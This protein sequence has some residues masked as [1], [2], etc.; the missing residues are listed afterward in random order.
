MAWPRPLGAATG[1]GVGQAQISK[2]GSPAARHALVEAAWSAAKAPGPLRAFAERTAARR[3]RQVALLQ[4][5]A[6]PG[7]GQ[8]RHLAESSLLAERLDIAHRQAAHEGADHQRLERLAGEE[9]LAPA[10]K[11]RLVNG[12]RASRTRGTSTTTSPSRH[13]GRRRCA[14]R[15]GDHGSRGAGAARRLPGD[16]RGKRSCRR[17][18]PSTPRR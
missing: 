4:R 17:S 1:G 6:E 3:G 8:L 9:A 14:L 5:A 12:A 10:G 7:G 16:A 18:R 15:R 13:R 2:E 11:S